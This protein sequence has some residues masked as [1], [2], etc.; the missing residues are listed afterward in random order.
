MLRVCPPTTIRR[1]WAD[2]FLSFAT[3]LFLYSF[4]ARGQFREP[5]IPC[6][7][8]FEFLQRTS[9]CSP[10]RLTAANGFPSE[11]AALSADH[12]TVLQFASAPKTNETIKT[13]KAEI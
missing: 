8:L 5:A 10:N 12:C 6:E 1:H 3:K 11:H 9:R 7:K 2:D 13:L 4:D